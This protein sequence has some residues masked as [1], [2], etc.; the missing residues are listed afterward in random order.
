MQKTIHVLLFGNFEF[1][2]N[3]T[4]EAALDRIEGNRTPRLAIHKAMENVAPLLPMAMTKCSAGKEPA[5]VGQC[6]SLSAIGFGQR[7]TLHGNVLERVERSSG[8]HTWC[9]DTIHHEGNGRRYE[10][11]WRRPCAPAGAS[12]QLVQEDPAVAARETQHNVSKHCI[13]A[14]LA[15]KA[16]EE[17]RAHG[18]RAGVIIAHVGLD[19]QVQKWLIFVT[20]ISGWRS[21][22]RVF[23]ETT[24]T[25]KASE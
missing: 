14:N 24:T 19:E 3:L 23:Q 15:T 18:P 7:P 1:E 20:I 2:E 10:I 5:G 17:L 16:A 22:A 12:Q 21:G 25:G 13:F 6:L 4:A 11:L 8:R 9:L